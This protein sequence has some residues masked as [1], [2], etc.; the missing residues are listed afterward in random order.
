M[1]AVCVSW[2]VFVSTVDPAVVLEPWPKAIVLVAV[3]FPGP[4]MGMLSV[5]A[6]SKLVVTVEGEFNTEETCF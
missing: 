3:W 2:P 6:V 4:V 5:T 1:A